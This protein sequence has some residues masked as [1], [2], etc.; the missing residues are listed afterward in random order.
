MSGFYKEFVTPTFKKVTLPFLRGTEKQIKFANDIR[1]KYTDIFIRK[2]QLGYNPVRDNGEIDILIQKFQDYVNHPK[3][4]DSFMWIENHCPRCGCAL[5]HAEA[6]SICT[7]EYCGYKK[8]NGFY[9]NTN[10]E[11]QVTETEQNF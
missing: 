6:F 4:I 3:M 9:T 8:G 11:P 1:N 10:A 7:N 2:V 5:T